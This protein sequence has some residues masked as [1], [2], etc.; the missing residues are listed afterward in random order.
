MDIARAAAWLA[1]DDADYV[2]G[3]ALAIDGGE[4]TGLAWSRQA[5]T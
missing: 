4:G 5:L 2:T 1:S 3:Q